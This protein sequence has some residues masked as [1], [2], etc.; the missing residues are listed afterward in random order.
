MQNI[1]HIRQEIS[2]T[3]R[4]IFE[5]PGLPITLLIFGYIEL[6]DEV[7]I[8]SSSMI[9]HRYFGWHASSAG[10]LIASLGAF[11]LPADYVVNKA[12]CYYSERKIM[13]WSILATTVGLLG[14]LNYSAMF[15]DIAG[16]ITTNNDN[17]G[18]SL[19]G[20][21]VGREIASLLTKKGE[22]KYN[23]DDEFGHCYYIIFLSTVFMGTIM[24][25]GVDTSIMTKVTPA[26]LNDSFINSG[27]L[28]TLIGTIARV[29][30]DVMITTS[31]FLDVHIYVDFVNATFAPLLLLSF[32]GIFLVNKYYQYLA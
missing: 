7:L 27:L 11:V 16:I 21:L 1:S 13:L 3:I 29:L 26:A 14:I 15:Y 25:E 19:S 22:F 28:A 2:R 32:A 8:S 6:V 12:S 17:Y 20:T 9:I 23:N 4:L 30:A 31:A 24:L 10:F 18:D 5:N